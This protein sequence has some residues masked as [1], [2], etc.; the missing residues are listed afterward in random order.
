MCILI[1]L[2]NISTTADVHNAHK[3]CVSATDV[4]TKPGFM[5]DLGGSISYRH[6]RLC[7]SLEHGSASDIYLFEQQYTV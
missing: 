7:V 5:R 1:A 4:V 6:V 2:A 3:M